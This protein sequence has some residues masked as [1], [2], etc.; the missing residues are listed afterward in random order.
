MAQNP[1][2]W[3]D[4]TEYPF[5]SHFYQINGQ[6]LHY[7]DEGKGETL[8]FVHGTPSWS[9]EYRNVIRHL[10]ADFRCIAVDHIGFGLS[11]KPE[12]YDYST[13]NH[14]K[15]LER[16]ILDHDLQNL[17][18]V[19][20]DFGGPIGLHFALRHPDRIAR[21]VIFNSWL[22]SSENDP[23]FITYSKALKS[24]LLPFLYKRLNLSP[25]FILPRSYGRHKPNRHILKHYTKPFANSKQRNGSLAFARS[26]L[27]DQQWFEGLWTQR[28]AISK[29]PALFLW[30]MQDPVITPKNLEKFESAFSNST[31]VTFDISGHFPQDEEPEK[32]AAA[33]HRFM[34]QRDESEKRKATKTRIY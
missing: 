27:H 28:E 29:K 13:A 22:W 15:T 2:K 17:T 14:S 23:E 24:P 7:I 30:G 18:L 8:L 19:V 20:H 9:F 6:R 12:Q 16:F 3:L 21:L 1:F 31:T 34:D 32:A 25:R 11:D 33:I 4:R 10:K 26:L 5:N